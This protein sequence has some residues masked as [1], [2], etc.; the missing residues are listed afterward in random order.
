[1]KHL[2]L[3]SLLFLVSEPSTDAKAVFGALDAYAESGDTAKAKAVFADLKL[4]P[5]KLIE[6]IRAG[7]PVEEAKTGLQSWKVKDAWDVET[8]VYVKVDAGY[9]KAKPAGIIVLLHGLGGDGKQ[10]RDRLFS[11]FAAA[12]NFIIVC[13]TAQK[14]AEEAKAE[15]DPGELAK[16]PHWW[17][18]KPGSSIF[19]A[20][21]EARRKYAVDADR[22]VL[23]GYSM[24]GFGTWNIGL[25]YP[26][27]FAAIVP[28]AGGISRTEY[29]SPEDKNLRPLVEN[30]RN[31]PSYFI[32]GDADS[33]V[34]VKYDRKTRDQMKAFGIDHTYV[35]VPKGKHLLDMSEG[36]KLM[37]G[38]QEWLKEKKRTGHPRKITYVA[39][40]DYASGVW[41]ARLEGKV[42]PLARLDAEVKDGNVIDLTA[43]GAESATVW[44]DEEL[45]D[46][47]K[48]VVV[49]SG[50]KELFRGRVEESFDAVL[51]SWKGREDPGLVYRAKVAISL[52]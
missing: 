33:T 8:D 44:L 47:S 50:G 40:G 36:G 1:M 28:M 27:R 13:P 48:E 23:A 29:I 46:L 37:T 42:Q 51:E 19:T 16:L 11:K 39:A 7:R 34:S 2:L 20:L 6:I 49:T 5:A 26:D 38:V 31:V 52:K 9:D 45:V 15:D 4:T 3:L 17:V 35:E 12:N 41:W 22:V 21:R 43:K 25:R 32:H 24:G 14:P 10:L 18:Y 30:A